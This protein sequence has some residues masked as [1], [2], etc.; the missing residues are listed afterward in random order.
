MI[1]ILEWVRENH[2]IVLLAILF[3]RPVRMN[4]NINKEK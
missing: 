2:L 3:F 1:E 4:V